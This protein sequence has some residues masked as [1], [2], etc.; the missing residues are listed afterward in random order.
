MFLRA[1]SYPVGTRNSSENTGQTTLSEKP[2]AQAGAI[3]SGSDSQGRLKRQVL[4]DLQR[5]WESLRTL[6][7]FSE[8]PA[9]LATVERVREFIEKAFGELDGDE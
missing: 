4:Q 2:G 1:I 3:D 6:E 5:A 8:D 7:S 9:K